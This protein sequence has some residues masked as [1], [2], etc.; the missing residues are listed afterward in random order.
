MAEGGGFEPPVPFKGTHAFQAC[1]LNHSDTPP[2]IE[3][4]KLSLPAGE[5]NRP[6]I[7]NF[8]EINGNVLLVCVLTYYFLKVLSASC[9]EVNMSKVSGRLIVTLVLAFLVPRFAPA[10][11]GRETTRTRCLLY[12]SD[13]ADE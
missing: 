7:I 2:Q 12:T 13:A 1:S 6:R 8:G 10:E 4:E 9:K 11:D 3:R 5:I